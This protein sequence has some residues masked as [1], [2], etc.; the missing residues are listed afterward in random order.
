MSTPPYE[1]PF[2]R[3]DL[4]DGRRSKD[5]MFTDDPDVWAAYLRISHN[6]CRMTV[7]IL[8]TGM[9]SAAIEHPE[10]D[11]DIL[12]HPNG[13]GLP[14]AT[15]EMMKRFTQEGFEQWLEDMKGEPNDGADP[16]DA[17]HEQDLH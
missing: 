7:E 12:V 8:S 13:P 9:I 3:F 11:Y 2:T 5:T 14:E 15:G 4:P 17:L 10:G 6:G 1:I 16:F